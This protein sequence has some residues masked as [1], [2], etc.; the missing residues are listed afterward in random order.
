[1]FGVKLNDTVGQGK[2]EV[3]RTVKTRVVGIVVLNYTYLVPQPYP[4]SETGKRGQLA[5]CGW[6]HL[7]S[8]AN[9]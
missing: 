4:E 9:R 1:M 8:V 6:C 5:L 7:G 2:I 3:N